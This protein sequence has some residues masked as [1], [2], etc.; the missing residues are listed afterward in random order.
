MKKASQN[1]GTGGEKQRKDNALENFTEPPS[2]LQIRGQKM[3]NSH[4]EPKEVET[5]ARGLE[6][7]PKVDHDKP[8]LLQPN[9]Q[10]HGSNT[11]V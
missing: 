8:R 9:L 2:R 6:T 1:E 4:R 5:M 7:L 3:G 10:N 11:T